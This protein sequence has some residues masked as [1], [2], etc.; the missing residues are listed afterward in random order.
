MVAP[1]VASLVRMRVA[2][3]AVRALSAAC[4]ESV[5]PIYLLEGRCYFRHKS[6]EFRILGPVDA[7]DEGKPLSIGGPR[8]RALLAL[9]LLHA[10]ELVSSDRLIDELWAAEQ[11]KDP[12]TALQSQVSRLRKALD[13]R[14]T[15]QSHGYMLRVARG[16]LDLDRFQNFVTEAEELAAEERARRLREALALWHGAPLSNVA[17]EPF[18]ELEAARLD[19][20]RVAALEERINADLEL[21]RHTDLVGELQALVGEHPLRE[22]L[23]GQLMLALYRCG[24]QAEALEVFRHGRQLLVEELGLEPSAELKELE[25]AILRQDPGLVVP[26]RRRRVRAKAEPSRHPWRRRAIVAAVVLPALLAP[27]IVLAMLDEGESPTPAPAAE[28]KPAAAS[29]PVKVARRTTFD[30][31]QSPRP[32]ARRPSPRRAQPPASPPPAASVS[33]PPRP[34]AAPRK[35]KSTTKPKRARGPRAAVRDTTTPRTPPPPPTSP[36]PVGEHR[37]ITDD[38]ANGFDQRIWHRLI[39]GTGVEAEVRN[40]RFEVTIGADAVEGGPYNVIAG[41][42]GTH[43]RFPGDFDARVEYELLRWPAANGVQ[44]SLVAFFA[45]A[46][47]SRESYPGGDYYQS[48]I[49]PS[50]EQTEATTGTS[51]ALRVAR[52]NGTVTTYFR[53]RDGSWV[54][55]QSGQATGVAVLSPAAQSSNQ[56]FGDKEVQVAFDNF[57]VEGNATNCPPG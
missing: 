18:A 3:G 21:G 51:G 8:Q 17:H 19:E 1:L 36:P 48:W 57:L 32:R 22:R 55:I 9:L 15:G 35:A 30:R 33:A 28:P 11:P 20:L 53:G 25:A 13:G 29:A 54:R 46:R 14:I 49:P 42:L 26:Q 23:R 40:G 6:V 5:R 7:L 27:T 56:R 38:F 4:Q 39:T 31:P 10:N 37:R 24:R 34:A 2:G 12:H 50:L 45:D 16:E 52:Q 43:C 41:Q 44:V 47:V